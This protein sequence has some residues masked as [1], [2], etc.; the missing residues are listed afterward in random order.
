[1]NPRSSSALKKLGLP[2]TDA[3][4]MPASKQRFPDGAQYRFEIPSTESPRMLRALIEE[5]NRYKIPIHRISQ[6]S[7]IMMLTDD[8]IREML[9]IG[10][11]Y[12]MEVN[13]FV[14]PRAGFDIGGMWAAP[15]G[16]FIQWQNRGQDQLRYAIDDVLRACDLGCRSVLLADIGLIWVIAEMRRAG[17]LPK[18]LVIKTSAVMALANAAA[19][20]VA[21]DLGGDT[22]NIASDLAIA[23]IGA[24]RQACKAVIDMYVEVPD[25]LGGFI[26]HYETPE[27]IRVA[28]PIYV[29]L[30]LRNSPDIYPYGTHI[31]TTAVA[32]SRERVRRA[33][34]VYDQIQR[35]APGLKISK[36]GAKGLALPEI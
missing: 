35:Q 11:D 27:L 20:K 3:H 34:L 8:E 10:R 16:K 14:G 13:L 19:C 15:T 6:G 17:K 23:Q 1:M 4:S 32:L 33:R 25:G 26:R 36:L 9:A 2:A 22:I 30:G 5:A 12:G 7:G 24:I 18:N 28:S 31:E 21:E 29:K